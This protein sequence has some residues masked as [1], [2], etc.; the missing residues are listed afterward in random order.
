[1]KIETT[2]SDKVKNSILTLIGTDSKQEGDVFRNGKD[3]FLV[4]Y[5]RMEIIPT[6]EDNKII[7]TKIAYYFNNRSIGF[8]TY[9]NEICPGQVLVLEQHEGIHSISINT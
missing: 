9:P 8:H 6:I 3:G 7:E 4:R 1:M 2:L 5:N